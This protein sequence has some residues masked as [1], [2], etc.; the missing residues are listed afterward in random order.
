MKYINT[1]ENLAA[2]TAD[3]NRPTS[4]ST[5]SNIQDGTGVLFEGKNVIAETQY[6]DIGDTVVYDK[7]DLTHKVV[8][9]G[10]LNI[11][12]LPANYV[13]G[14]TV[15]YRETKKVYVVANSNAASDRWGAGYKVKLTGFDLATGGSFTITVNS[16]TTATITYTTSD[17]LA[18]IATSI[19]AALAAAGFTSATGWN[20]V[21]VSDYILI[22]QNWFTP[23]ITTFNI[24]DASNKITKAILTGN[25]QTAL[26]GVITPYG[27]VRRKDGVQTSFAGGNLERS[28]A[29]YSASGSDITGQTVGAN[30]VVRESRFNSTDN[31]LLVSFYGTYRNYMADKMTRY[32]FSKGTVLSNGRADTV[33][34]ASI[35]Y[36]DHNGAILPAYP[37]AY[38]AYTYARTAVGYITGFEAGNWHL[39]STTEMLLLISQV[40]NGLAGIT[41]SNMDVINKGISAAGGTLISTTSNYWASTEY[42]SYF[43]WFYTGT[44]GVLYFNGKYN[45]LSVR[46]VLALIL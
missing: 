17:T 14:G 44:G 12:T 26:T 23:N 27:F 32:P 28:I 30:S 1:Y 9:S 7:T 41:S 42:S 13:I 37:A 3:T 25:Y 5:V 21:N 10:T 15:Y 4:E 35:M 34:L 29:Y 40:T 6:A 31:P 43:A 18:T 20:I 39:P 2:Y 19:A 8:K 46:P 16:T 36:T 45:S 33:A 24:T 11:V 38:N 22:Q